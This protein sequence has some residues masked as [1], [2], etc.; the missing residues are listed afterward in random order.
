M[1]ESPQ[2]PLTLL[3]RCVGDLEGTVA[4][5]L[6]VGRRGAAR[7]VGDEARDPALLT[8]SHAAGV[9]SH[10]GRRVDK[11]TWRTPAETQRR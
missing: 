4:A 3:K 11:H 2:A 7:R 8:A 9:Q 1:A 5:R 6:H 10:I